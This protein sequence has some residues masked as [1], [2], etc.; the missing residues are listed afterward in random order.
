MSQDPVPPEP[1]EE[2]ELQFA[3]VEPTTPKAAAQIA[4]PQCVVCHQPIADTYFAVGKQLVCPNCHG[5]HAAQLS[6]GSGFVRFLK[7]T[8]LGSG[9]GLIGAL[10]WYGVRRVTGYEVGLIAV[11][12]GFLVGGAIR[13]GSGG[14]GGI[15]YQIL[16]VM[17]TYFAV[18]ANYAPD[19][20]AAASK[21]HS[22]GAMMVFLVVFAIV[23]GP[24]VVAF[25]NLI[26]ALIICFALWEAWKINKGR[27]VAFTGPYSLNSGMASAL[28]PLPAS[29]TSV[30]P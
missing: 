11:V 21:E 22:S 27:R 13:A 3:S 18:G 7:A 4:R 10:I 16:A 25:Q 24:V 28:P 9:G 23:A 12:V 1:P 30:R 6:D 29:G 20:V 5:Q 15:G 8:A 2:Y 17:L 19:V 14:R 26:G